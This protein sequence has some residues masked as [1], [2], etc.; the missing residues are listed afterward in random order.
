VHDIGLS[1][2]RQVLRGLSTKADRAALKTHW[3]CI[4]T[5]NSSR[6]STSLNRLGT[7]LPRLVDQPA[8]EEGVR[9]K[10]S[11]SQDRFEVWHHHGSLRRPAE[12]A[13]MLQ[14][15]QRR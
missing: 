15:D 9:D 11:K 14:F 3:Y 8:P 6:S 5:M 4:T 1:L 13:L 12:W 2:I 7:T 10:G